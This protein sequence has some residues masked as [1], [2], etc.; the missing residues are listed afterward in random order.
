MNDF[1][2]ESHATR[3]VFGYETISKVKEELQVLGGKRA[4]VIATPGFTDLPQKIA[5][6]LGEL[7]VGIH[8][9]AVQHVPNDVVEKS[10]QVVDS[11]HVDSLIAVGGGSAI[12]LAKAIALNK[13][14]PILAIPTTYA[15]S[16]MTPI[17]GIT[18]NGL[19][20]T[21][22]DLRVKP[23]TIIY[24]PELTMTLPK[25]LTI[26][27]GMNAIAHCVEALYSE[28]K[29]PIISLM[30]EEGISVLN[31]SLPKIMENPNHKEA[32]SQALYGCWLGGTALGSVGMALHH[33]LCHVLGGSYN[34]PHAETHTVILPYA[35]WY[36]GS[37]I[38][39]EVKIL[40]RAL[41]TEEDNVA[42][43][44]FDLAKSLNAPT[45]LAEIGMKE[46][47]LD[48]AS[49]YVTKNPYFNPRPIDK[50]A[51]RQLLGLAYRGERPTGKEFKVGAH[52]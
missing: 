26:T 5:K 1:V 31:L 18:E 13:N 35:I 39:D 34:L 24:D 25:G 41:G 22:K 47:D 2:Y 7:C 46:E 23:K 9:E 16:E 38:I 51:I 8:Q 19:K 43:F 14:L 28:S 48:L 17:W 45:S 10:L 4:L 32:R 37:H 33:K 12:G 30:A 49:E 50:I 42:G 27:S 15:G 20:K 21:G 6:L 11:Q 3:V 29:N 52:L 40:A 36:N 44:I